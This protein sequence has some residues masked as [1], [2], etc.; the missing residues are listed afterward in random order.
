MTYDDDDDDDDDDDG[1][2]DGD[3]DAAADDDDDDDDDD[4][5]DGNGDGDFFFLSKMAKAGDCELVEVAAPPH[6]ATNVASLYTRR[7]ITCHT[8]P[9]CNG[10]CPGSSAKSRSHWQ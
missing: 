3:G 4:D 9:S 2:G 7:R 10:F 1:D 5:G 6:S 8:H